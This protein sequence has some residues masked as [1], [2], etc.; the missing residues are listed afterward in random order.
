MRAFEFKVGK[1]K[2]DLVAG[3]VWHP[4]HQS[5]SARTKEIRDFA[6]TSGHDFK[7]LRGTESPHV[8]FAKKPKVLKPGSYLL[9]QS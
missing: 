1:K 3:L 8:G 7:V 9:R 4:V 2:L 6:K 5:G